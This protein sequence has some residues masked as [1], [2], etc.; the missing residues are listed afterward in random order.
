ML[1]VGFGTTT[2]RVQNRDACFK[3][4]LQ[5]FFLR[6]IVVLVLLVL[7]VHA[8]IASSLDD[9]AS[10]PDLLTKIWHVVLVI[11]GKTQ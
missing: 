2:N 4:F 11:S 9:V 8:E 10:A 3:A 7:Q 5:E 6:N 1:F